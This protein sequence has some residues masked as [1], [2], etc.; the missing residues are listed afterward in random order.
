M[1]APETAISSVEP[2]LGSSRTAPVSPDYLRAIFDLSESL[3]FDFFVIS[4]TITSPEMLEDISS[5]YQ[6][7]L[8]EIYKNVAS[9]IAESPPPTTR[10]F[11]LKCPVTSGTSRNSS[12]FRSSSPAPSQIDSA[13]LTQLLSELETLHLQYN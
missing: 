3:Y 1:N 2:S 7:N 12:S 10:I 8:R 13:P 4:R 6:S 9:S 11:A 5:V